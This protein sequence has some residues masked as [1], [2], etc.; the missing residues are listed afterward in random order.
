MENEVYDVEGNV[1]D[2][3]KAYKVTQEVVEIDGEF[4]W[5]RS[6]RKS[7]GKWFGF[8]VG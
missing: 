6:Q 7:D 8:V 5:P 3:I 4:L 1:I 2:S